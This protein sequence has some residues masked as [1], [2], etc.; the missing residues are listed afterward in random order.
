MII[1]DPNLM[2]LAIDP[3]EDHPPLIIDPDGMKFPQLA[4]ELL[5]SIRRRQ[6]QV[7]EPACSINRF[8]L[9]LGSAGDPRKLA[10]PPIVEKCLRMS[11][12]E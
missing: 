4:L 9:A 12:A 8:E 6:H 1:H 3:P 11:V 7:V 2:R 5:Q 10:N